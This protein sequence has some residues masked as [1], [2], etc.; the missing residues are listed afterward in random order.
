MSTKTVRLDN[1]T[2]EA[3]REIRK[4]TG[5]SISEVLKEGILVLKKEVDDK[6]RQSPFD[7][8]KS[9][10]L[11]EGGYSIAPSTDTRKGVRAAIKKK[12]NK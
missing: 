3:L 7:V 6:N 10:D 1:E 5:L 9:L 8:Y 12:L 2:E 11:G 4:Q